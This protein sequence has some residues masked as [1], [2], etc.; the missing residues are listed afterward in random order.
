MCRT[1]EEQAHRAG[2]PSPH[3]L[4]HKRP[5]KSGNCPKTTKLQIIE[6]YNTKYKYN[7]TEKPTKN[8]HVHYI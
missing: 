5:V 1:P 4:P 3:P 8:I 7:S 2:D 6:N